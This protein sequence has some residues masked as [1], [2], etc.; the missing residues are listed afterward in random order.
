MKQLRCCIALLCVFLTNTALA[1]IDYDIIDA[2]VLE[3]VITESSDS[4]FEEFLVFAGGEGV[5]WNSVEVTGL[6]DT[7]AELKFKGKY[8]VPVLR[9]K[10]VRVIYQL[11]LLP[12]RPEWTFQGTSAEL[13]VSPC[14]RPC[15]RRIKDLKELVD[16]SRLFMGGLVTNILREEQPIFP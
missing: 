9:D 15:K 16:G 10:T 11:R 6:T 13:K 3:Q 2:S 7:T 14:R 8:H 4:L 1:D 12:G 5:S